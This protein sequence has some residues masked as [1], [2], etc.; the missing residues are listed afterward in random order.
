[1]SLTDCLSLFHGCRGLHLNGANGVEQWL[2]SSTSFWREQAISQVL[3]VEQEP[4]E[5]PLVLFLAKLG[6]SLGQ[7]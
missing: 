7:V 2:R 6:V 4:S 1:M 5:R 3:E